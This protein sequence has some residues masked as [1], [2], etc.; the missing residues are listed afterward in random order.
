MKY[1]LIVD[2][3]C[4]L[5]EEIKSKYRYTIAPLIVNLNGKSYKDRIEI[6]GEEILNAY[7]KEHIIPTTSTLS[8]GEIAEML[9]A[10]LKDADH[11]FFLTI[12]SGIS[13]LNQ[14]IQSVIKTGEYQDKV[15][16]L[17]SR[18]L[19]GSYG[20]LALGV[21]KDMEEGLSAKE[22][23]ERHLERAKR[24]VF[25]CT[26]ENLELL[27]RGGRC[28][29]LSYHIGS[30]FHLHPIIHTK[31]GRLTV[32]NL[33]RAKSLDKPVDWIISCF[34][35]ELEKDS[36]DL[37]FPV[38]IDQVESPEQAKRIQEGLKDI[39]PL[40]VQASGIIVCHTGCETIGLSYL[41]KKPA[42]SI[43]Q[44]I[45]AMTSR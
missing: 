36:I 23:E 45:S 9:N 44:K 25:Q 13:S 33:I 40:Q 29:G 2:S 17:D 32:K 10:G 38:I 42:T 21:L 39:K 4:D 8:L 26:I 6:T 5:P 24:T 1:K 7:Q 3:S 37:R 34:K 22:I 19:S 16:L 41:L 18:S 20:I 35:K 12:S 31:E 30:R 28:S 43:I 15:T 11:L 27:H 14:N